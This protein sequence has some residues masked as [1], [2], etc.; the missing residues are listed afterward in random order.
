MSSKLT[1]PTP[2]DRIETSRALR[3]GIIGAGRMGITHLSILGG[4]PAVKIVAVADDSPLIT[5]ALTRFRPDIRLFDNYSKMLQQTALDAVLIATPPHLHAAMIDAALDADLSI[6]VEKPITLHAEDARRLSARSRQKSGTYQV[7]YVNRFNDIFMKVKQLIDSKILG[8]L[9]SFRSDMY[10]RT[11]THPTDGSGWRDTREAGG[12]CLYEFGSHAIDLMV[13]LFGKPARVTGSCLTPVYSAKVEDMVHTNVI[14][15]NGLTGSLAVNWSDASYRKPTNKVEILGKNGK[16][17]ADQHELKIFL[18]SAVPP[19]ITGWNVGYITDTFT[20]VPFY[21]RGN[22]FTRQLFHFAER[23]QH[24]DQRNLSDFSDATI[25]QEV[26][27]M[28]LT[29]AGMER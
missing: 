10:G 6:F 8:Q 25:T 9:F 12:G 14:Y 24:P 7:G 1:D 15:S 13:Y 29:D 4:Y 28:V 5:R 17:I 22:E 19:Y 18:N 20:P 16:I 2:P 3:V 11:V 23:A 27:D 21:V 26:I